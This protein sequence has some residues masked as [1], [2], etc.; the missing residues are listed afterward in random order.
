MFYPKENSIKKTA[1][2]ICYIYT[3]IIF[4]SSIS[5]FFSELNSKE[6]IL[7]FAFSQV[8]TIFLLLTLYIANKNSKISG[9][10]LI[11]ISICLA[12]YLHT[13]ISIFCFITITIPIVVAGIIYIIN[14]VN[15]IY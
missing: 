4:I 11:I 10:M 13:Y 9:C 5:V 12:I 3:V 1:D 8:T 6:K 7:T 14:G 2:I 15:N